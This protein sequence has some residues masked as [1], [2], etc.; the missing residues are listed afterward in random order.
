MAKPDRAAWLT[1]G[2]AARTHSSV[3]AVWVGSSRNSRDTAS[4]PV[5]LTV[6]CSQP[7]LLQALASD[8]SG[9]SL[10]EAPVVIAEKRKLFLSFLF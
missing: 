7:T 3:T 9:L 4:S 8:S 10:Q 5:R 2:S 1:I 6:T